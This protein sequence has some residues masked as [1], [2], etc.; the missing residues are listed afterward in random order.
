MSTYEYY[1]GIFVCDFH[2]SVG[3][4]KHIPFGAFGVVNV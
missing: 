2:Q 4:P 3:E 1:I